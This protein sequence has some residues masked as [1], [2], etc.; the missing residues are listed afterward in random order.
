MVDEEPPPFLPSFLHFIPVSDSVIHVQHPRAAAPDFVIQ[1]AA[2]GNDATR[3]K[4]DSIRVNLLNLD[5]IPVSTDLREIA[6]SFAVYDGGIAHELRLTVLPHDLHFDVVN[7]VTGS[8]SRF[9]VISA[10]SG[11]S[12]ISF[13]L[14]S[15]GIRYTWT[16]PDNVARL[17]PNTTC[18]LTLY[19]DATDSNSPAPAKTLRTLFKPKQAY[20]SR[21]QVA[22]YTMRVP[23]GNAFT[24]SEINLEPV[25]ETLWNSTDDCVV[26]LASA[27]AAMFVV[28][29]E[30]Q[31]KKR[32]M[33]ND[34]LAMYLVAHH[35]R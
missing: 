3:E 19:M 10:G 4:Q 6:P 8:T 11:I 1:F 25:L 18:T 9:Q 28:K 33:V 35:H 5:R 12:G 32:V 24:I 14:E 23:T 22:T 21:I 17:K 27:V 20:A 2:N 7:V 26:V 16:V 13:K 29:Q 15:T 31:N 34:G 30:L